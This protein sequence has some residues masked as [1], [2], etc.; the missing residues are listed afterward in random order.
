M[1]VLKDLENSQYPKK[2]FLLFGRI[3]LGSL[4]FQ[5]MHIYWTSKY[6]ETGHFRFL[7]CIHL[8]KSLESKSTVI[9]SILHIQNS[10]LLFHPIGAWGDIGHES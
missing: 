2:Y 3:Q 10:F 9:S 7:F 4:L 5:N 6:L 8:F 1:Y